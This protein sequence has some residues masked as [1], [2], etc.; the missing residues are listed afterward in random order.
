[1][2]ALSQAPDQVQALVGGNAAA[3]DQKD[4]LCR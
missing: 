2:A 3:D 1:M 4:A